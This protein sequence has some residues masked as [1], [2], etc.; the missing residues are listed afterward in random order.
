[1]RL[2][3]LSVVAFCVGMVGC[4]GLPDGIEP[5]SDFDADRY[6]GTWYEIA[7]FDHSFEEGLTNVV[8]EY[9]YNDDGS[10]KVINRGYSPEEGEWQEADG[11][12][13]FVGSE[14]VGHLKVSF[15]GPFYSSYAVFGLDREN[16]QYSYVTGYNR[17][18]LWFLSR[19]PTVSDEALDDFRSA[20]QAQGFDM[21]G[22]IMVDQDRHLSGSGK[23]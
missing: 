18:Y 20:A 19:T 8:A 17:D 13:W 6:L 12:A 7:R 2:T 1:M 3:S 5:V 9:S 10:I 11:K 23:D 22:L 15:F 14:D 16:Y 21:D 4:T